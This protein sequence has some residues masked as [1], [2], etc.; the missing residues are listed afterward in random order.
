MPQYEEQLLKALVEKYRKS[1]KD[2][3]SNLISRRTQLAP[4]RLY[5][6]YND[7]DADLA[8]VDAVNEAVRA[9]AQ[10]DWVQYTQT[11]LSNE[12]SKIYLN[13]ACVGAIENYLAEKY[14]YRPRDAEL[15]TLRRLI[16]R[17]D[18]ATPA[19]TAEC[20]R[21][22]E[23]LARRSVPKDSPRLEDIFKALL[24][25][26]CNQR[27]LY[28]R[29]ASMLIYGGSKYF[30]E[31]TLD[32]VAAILRRRY[33]LPCAEEELN[34]EILQRF[35]IYKE[36]PRLCLK[37]AIVLTVAGREVDVGLFANGIEFAAEE[38]ARIEKVKLAAGALTTV[39]NKTSYQRLQADNAAYFYL[40]GFMS[41]GQ[42]DFLKKIY[43]D[44]PHARYYHFGDID[45]GGLFIYEHLRRA[46]GV[47][48]AMYKMS[49]AELADARNQ[50]CLLPLTQHDRERLASLRGNPEFRGLVD[51]MLEHNVKLE[52]EIISLRQ[53]TREV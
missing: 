20:A 33:G 2:D 24:F 5:K 42:R 17:Y 34:D 16:A 38:S 11:P 41:R 31:N 22:K 50:S 9:A 19:L 32:A 14:G 10:R 29:E 37:G 7:N 13:D 4:N 36:Q 39:E 30:E 15:E 49:E 26:E 23:A 25:V 40:G 48:F 35:A 51:Y 12:I 18:N 53:S 6:K 47:P 44:N 21:L 43:R 8:K 3:G 45:A 27:R 46:T 1:K 52:Q 28:V